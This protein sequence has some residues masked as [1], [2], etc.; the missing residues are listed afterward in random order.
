ME[1]LL[2]SAEVS[3]FFSSILSEAAPMAPETRPEMESSA[4][5]PLACSLLAS[6]EAVAEVPWTVSETYWAALLRELPI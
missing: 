5:L 2:A 1:R 6:L 4:V 3:C